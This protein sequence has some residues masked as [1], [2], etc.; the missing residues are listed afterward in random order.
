MLGHILKTTIAKVWRYQRSFLLA[1]SWLPLGCDEDVKARDNAQI[2]TNRPSSRRWERR[3]SALPQNLQLVTHV[4]QRLTLLTS[5][6][7]EFASI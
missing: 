1:F 5:Q 2:V 3:S 7:T 4:L 6:G